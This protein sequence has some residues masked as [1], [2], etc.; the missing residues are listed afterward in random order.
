MTIATRLSFFLEDFHGLPRLVGRSLL[1]FE[2]AIEI[3]L[4]QQIIRIEFEKT[5]EQNFCLDKIACAEFVEPLFVRL[6]PLQELRIDLFISSP[7]KRED[8]YR[9]AFSFHLHPGNG[10]QMKFVP[11]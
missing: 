6:E 9:F 10:A 5:R 7:D 11:H 8:V 3:H 4:G 2:R 1:I